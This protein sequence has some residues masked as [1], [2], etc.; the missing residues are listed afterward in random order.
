R[1]HRAAVP[2]PAARR[3]GRAVR[4]DPGL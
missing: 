1:E 2:A 3:R 4:Q